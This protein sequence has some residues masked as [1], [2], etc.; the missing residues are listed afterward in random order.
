ML[1]YEL[2]ALKQPYEDEDAFDV[3]Q[4]VVSGKRPQLPAVRVL[5]CGCL[6]RLLLTCYSQLHESYNELIQIFKECTE[7]SPDV[8]PNMETL[9]DKLMR[10][11]W[12]Q[13]A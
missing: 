7:V 6:A 9:R 2:L 11:H 4:F 10:L 5:L 1:M 13:T 12:S 8:R 3:P